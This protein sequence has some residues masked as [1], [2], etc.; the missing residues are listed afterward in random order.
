MP[1]FTALP[2]YIK[3]AYM[4]H[5]FPAAR[6]SHAKGPIIAGGAIRDTLL[7]APVKDIDIF[8]NV[9]DAHFYNDVIL[10]WCRL[11]KQGYGSQI[12]DPDGQAYPYSPSVKPK[13]ASLTIPY[14]QTAGGSS[15]YSP[16]PGGQLTI[17]SANI[18]GGIGV[19]VAEASDYTSNRKI[20]EVYEMYD[21]QIG[22][23]MN[24]IFTECP[25]VE[26]VAKYFDFGIC[27]AWYDGQYVHMHGDFT[28]DVNNKTITM[29]LPNAHVIECYGSVAAGVE[30]MQDHAERIQWKYPTHKIVM[31]SV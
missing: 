27:K 2:Q 29:V 6:G 20:V 26:Y 24:L 19:A 22:V 15:I 16:N 28:N 5:C 3:D 31:P 14:N 18:F 10:S 23:D 4:Q 17:S 21:N 30:A 25:P 8:V 11:G 13:V 9:A 12:F 1:L 7:N